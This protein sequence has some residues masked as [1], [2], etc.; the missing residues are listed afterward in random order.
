VTLD[1]RQRQAGPATVLLAIDGSPAADIAVDLVAALRW[2]A[3]TSIRVIEA[4]DVGPGLFGGPWPGMAVS[5]AD[6]LETALHAQA[7]RDVEAARG[8]VAAS[9]RI[10]STGVVSGRAATAIIDEA[11]RIAADLVVV[12]SRGHGTISSML[13]GSVSS[14]IIDHAPAPVLVARSH[15]VDRIVLA[16]DGSTCARQ[17]ADTLAAWPVFAGTPVRV[18]TVADIGLPWWTGIADPSV[19]ASADTAAI[20]ADSAD[21]ARREADELVGE[22]VGTLRATG[23]DATADRRDGD[24]ATEIIAAARDAAADLIVIGTHGRTGLA[25]LRLGSVASNVMRHA[26]CSVLVVR[27]THAGSSSAAKG[28]DPD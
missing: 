9:G 21:T 1:E 18:V 2:P 3:D 11:H 22:M 28:P 19:L 27:E 4:M 5:Q 10:V 25:R 16:W 14:E 8:R 24:A 12:G 23:H 26:P 6:D 17:A 20:I 13:L 7:M 15:Q